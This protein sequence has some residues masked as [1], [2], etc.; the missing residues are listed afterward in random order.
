VT[1][2]R[3]RGTTRIEIEL[4]G[5]PWRVVPL[6]ALQETALTVGSALDRTAARELGRAL[7]RHR[8]LAVA[9]GAL[10]SRDHTTAS[11]A[12]R[13]TA[14]GVR[15]AERS[16]TLAV[17]D[18]AGLVDDTRFAHDRAAVLARRGAGD[19]RIA[20]DLEREGVVPELAAAAIA[21]LEPERER[22]QR[23]VEGRGRTVRT[24]RFLAAQGFSEDALEDL[25]AEVDAGA[26]G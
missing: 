1:G 21:A 8:A 16:E 20:F 23:I 14:R 19:R 9:V 4:D 22:A 13:L 7:R 18:R 3:R 15:P 10:R 17:L 11:L 24:L 26:L 12:R 6:E 2:L 5:V 25:V